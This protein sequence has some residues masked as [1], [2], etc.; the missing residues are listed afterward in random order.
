MTFPTF[1]CTADSVIKRGICGAKNCYHKKSGR[2]LINILI[3][4]PV[5]VCGEGEGHIFSVIKVRSG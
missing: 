1:D 5:T 4:V 3:I 2:D